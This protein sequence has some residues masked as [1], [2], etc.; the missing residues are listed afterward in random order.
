MNYSLLSKTKKKLSAWRARRKYG[1]EKIPQ[2][3]IEKVFQ[4]SKDFKKSILLRELNLSHSVFN[5]YVKQRA[6]SGRSMNQRPKE[7]NSLKIQR[8]NFL[9]LPT[10]PTAPIL[11]VP[12]F[13]GEKSFSLELS[14]PGGIT[15]KIFPQESEPR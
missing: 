8:Q 14:F 6:V 15:L 12:G 11:K 5:K 4:L 7:R 9:Q 2:E 1:K 13:A 3:I 10:L